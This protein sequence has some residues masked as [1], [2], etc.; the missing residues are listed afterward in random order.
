MCRRRY[1]LFQLHNVWRN[2][3]ARQLDH[4]HDVDAHGRHAR[5]CGNVRGD[6]AGDDGG[7]DVALDYAHATSVSP[8]RSLSWSGASWAGHVCPWGWLFFRMEP[9]RSRR[10]L[11]RRGHNPG[12][13]ALRHLQPCI[14]PRWRTRVVHRRDLSTH[15]VEIGLLEALPRS[16][17]ACSP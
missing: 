13:D 16:A 8:S 1:S 3:H 17:D 15:T 11:D 2:A 14:A 7:H 5:G 4:E 12:R 9:L 10:L 6:V